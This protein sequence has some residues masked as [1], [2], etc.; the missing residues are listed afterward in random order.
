MG[1]TPGAELILKSKPM[2]QPTL[3]FDGDC[4]FCRRWVARWRAQTGQRVKY[5]PYQR[6]GMRFPGL[7]RED[8]ANAV[9]FIDDDGT[10]LSGADAI[11]RLH[12]FGLCGGRWLGAVLS[13]PPVIWFMRLGYRIVARNRSFFSSLRKRRGGARL[14]H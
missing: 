11:A 5:I 9:Q 1:D 3:V 12:R 13:V 4:C 8:C 2:T 6:L 10:I 7:S 14:A